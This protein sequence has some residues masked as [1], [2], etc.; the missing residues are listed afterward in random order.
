MDFSKL[1]N[2]LFIL[3]FSILTLSL[4]AQESEQPEFL[5]GL[6][7][8]SEEDLGQQQIMLDG[9]SI[10]V[11]KTDGTRVKGMELMQMMMKN[12]YYPDIYIDESK[13]I[14][15]FLLRPIT[16]EEK[17]MMEEAMANAQAM[18][19]ESSDFLGEEAPDFS[20]TDL[21]GNEYSKESLKGKVV[22]LNFWFI[23]CKPCIME[24]PELNGLVE[25]YKGKE[26]VFLGL[27][28]DRESRLRPFLEKTPF[29]YQIVP[30]SGQ[31]ANTFEVLGF[32]THIVIDPE[33]TV[34]WATT[35]LGPTTV[36]TLDHQI[37]TQ[38]A[39]KE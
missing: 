7:K 32:P 16:P 18:M 38:L 20:G 29:N 25:K 22:V 27:A 8:A 37:E 39:E 31:L 10:P 26:V 9:E 17:K 14:K 33:G 28:T 35:G 6:V 15:A 24:M 4:Q 30:N 13:E 23:A 36:E 21:D 19:D 1:S 12:E 34:V 2:Y 11:Y 5:K 3:L